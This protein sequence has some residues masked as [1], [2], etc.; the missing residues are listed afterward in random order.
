M[1]IKRLLIFVGLLI[2]G[3]LEP[4]EVS[5]GEKLRFRNDFK[6]KALNDYITIEV[7]TFGVRR[8]KSVI[9]DFYNYQ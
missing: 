5:F 6:F 2:I 8:V 9:N 7:T 3:S 4:I 1:E